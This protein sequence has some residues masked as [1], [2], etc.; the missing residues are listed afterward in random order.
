MIFCSGVALGLQCRCALCLVEGGLALVCLC[1][2]AFLRLV[3]A[4][5]RLPAGA[6]LHIA[7]PYAPHSDRPQA[8]DQ[9]CTRHRNINQ[10]LQVR[11]QH[12]DL[13]K[14]LVN[15]LKHPTITLL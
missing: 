13:T 4:L 2:T 9:H 12:Q 11:S 7:L 15:D 8:F 14:Q 10:L 3:F 6:A 1:A 5:A